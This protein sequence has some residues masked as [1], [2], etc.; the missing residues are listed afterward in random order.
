MFDEVPSSNTPDLPVLAEGA[1][2]WHLEVI[3]VAVKIAPVSREYETG[4]VTDS[5]S[6]KKKKRRKKKKNKER[7]KEKEK[8]A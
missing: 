7:K 4:P 2:V 8:R 6:Q 5:T 3:M 1:Y